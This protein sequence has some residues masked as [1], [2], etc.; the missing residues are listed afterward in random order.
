MTHTT[1]IVQLE[2]IL[3]K[4]IHGFS[5][6]FC[7]TSNLRSNEII[8]N[9]IAPNGVTKS[10]ATFQKNKDSKSLEIIWDFRIDNQKILDS[11]SKLSA[12]SQHLLT[13][14]HDLLN[15]RTKLKNSLL[16]FF[17]QQKIKR[18]TSLSDEITTSL[19]TVHIQIEELQKDLFFL[20]TEDISTYE[21][22]TSFVKSFPLN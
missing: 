22:I 18:L 10:L 13:K 20:P 17:S 7:F 9:Y 3:N 15:E 11:I 6:Q 4:S 8:L 14:Q 19:K 2:S 5:S 1:S 21:T 12:A 16:F